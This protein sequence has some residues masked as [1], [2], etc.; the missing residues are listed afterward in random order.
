MHLRDTQHLELPG[1]EPRGAILA[2][3][4]T[5]VGPV[6]IVGVHLGL[7]RRYRLLQLKAV[8]RA[9]NRRPEMPLIL[10]G[11]FNEWR[12][13][14][15]LGAVTQGVSFAHTP[16]SYP[17][18]RPVGRLDRIAHCRRLKP[19][20]TGTWTGKPAHVAS[21]HLPVWADMVRVS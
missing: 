9:V 12:S 13:P 1:L 2:E 20:D 7:I 8:M 15:V 17:A 4:E 16:P 5:P 21:D 19:V 6:R 18:L 10:A 14:A 11:D 3:I